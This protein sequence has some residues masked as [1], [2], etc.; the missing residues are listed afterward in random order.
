MVIF[1]K[2]RLQFSITGGQEPGVRSPLVFI[3]VLCVRVVGER[4]GISQFFSSVSVT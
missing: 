3:A 1:G 2:R 4:G